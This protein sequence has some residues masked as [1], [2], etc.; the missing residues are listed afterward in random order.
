MM[1]GSAQSPLRKLVLFLVCLALAGTILAGILYL[2]VELPAQQPARA[3]PN[4]PGS[5][6]P[7]EIFR[8]DCPGGCGN[9]Q[10]CLDRCDQLYNGCQYGG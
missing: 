10:A 4:G 6:R 5:S 3:P 7:C 9:D 8:T 2:T 1:P